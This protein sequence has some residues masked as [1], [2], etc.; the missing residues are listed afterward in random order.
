MSLQPI[1][2]LI[3]EQQTSFFGKFQKLS[4]IGS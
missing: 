4:C 1:L 3:Q 2:Q